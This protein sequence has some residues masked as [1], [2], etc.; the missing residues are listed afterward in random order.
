MSALNGG[1]PAEQ[2]PAFEEL[3]RQS[4]ADRAEIEAEL[5]EVAKIL[6]QLSQHL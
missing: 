6:E 1:L 5:Q 3:L 4:L 2:K